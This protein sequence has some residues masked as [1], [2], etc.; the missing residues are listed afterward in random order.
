MS[1]VRIRPFRPEDAAAMYEVH[2]RAFDGRLDEPR[3]AAR[4]H[5]AGKD[6][7]S[8]VAVTGDAVV[9]HVVFSPVT[10]DGPGADFTM[11]GLGPVGVLPEHQG[12]G[13]GSRLIREGLTACR[14][15]GYD[16][17]VV[18]GHPAYYRR[19]GFERAG[20][21]GLGNEYGVDDEFLVV[22]L[23]GSLMGAQATVRY[24]PEFGDTGA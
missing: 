8:L 19:F 11:V 3:I 6:P 22:S 4:L 10:L 14:S 24:Q 18:L 5:A 9:G 20:K 12:E 16:A 1:R 21:S 15:A 13:I 23:R 2:R 17:A 7:V